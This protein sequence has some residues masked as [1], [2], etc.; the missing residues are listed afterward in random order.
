M[1]PGLRFRI[2]FGCKCCPCSNTRRRGL[3]IT[4]S[5]EL[6]IA[7]LCACLVSLCRTSKPSMMANV[8]KPVLH[9]LL[10]RVPLLKD[11]LPASVKSL[12]SSRTG[13]SK[14]GP[15]KKSTQEDKDIELAEEG[16]AIGKKK[17][18]DSGDETLFDPNENDI[19][20]PDSI[21]RTDQYAV[22]SENLAEEKQRPQGRGDHPMIYQG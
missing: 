19:R 17:S 13:T 10:R 8:S 1:V 3:K 16:R 5:L 2:M 18:Q 6:N 15:S 21:L 20:W 22:T 7:I 4:S 11:K 12:F 14:S 9:P